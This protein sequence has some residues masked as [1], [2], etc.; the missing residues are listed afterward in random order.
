M[1]ARNVQLSFTGF[2]L[3]VALQEYLA[4]WVAKVAAA[5]KDYRSAMDA[6]KR[7]AA[8]GAAQ[9]ARLAARIARP[10]AQAALE[11]GIE[12]PEQ[13]DSW[14]LDGIDLLLQHTPDQGERAVEAIRDHLTEID[15]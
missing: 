2:T 10:A 11:A 9:D 12:D 14:F 8:Q 1:N 13:L 4:Q 3:A 7:P 15:A 6:M 5:E